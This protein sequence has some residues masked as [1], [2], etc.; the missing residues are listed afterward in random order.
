MTQYDPAFIRAH[1][2]RLYLQARSTIAVWA[3]GGTIIGIM[4]G[5]ML[6]VLL[7]AIVEKI[8]VPATIT[9]LFAVLSALIGYKIGKDIALDLKLKAQIALCQLKTEENTKRVEV[10]SHMMSQARLQPGA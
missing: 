6:G 8:A 1:A 3:I 4:A 9:P 10:I 7:F 2:D 5:S